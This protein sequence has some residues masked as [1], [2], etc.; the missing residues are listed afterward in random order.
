MILGIINAVSLE[1]QWHKPYI[2]VLST[3]IVNIVYIFIKNLN[4]DKDNKDE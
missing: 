2:N 4:N 3:V 1:Q